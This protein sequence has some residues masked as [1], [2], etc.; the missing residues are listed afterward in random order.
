MKDDKFE[1]WFNEDRVAAVMNHLATTDD[2]TADLKAGVQRTEFLAKLAEAFAYKA[3]SVGSVE[4]KKAEAKM[5]PKVQEAWETHFKAIADYEKARA[6]RARGDM[7]F[8]GWRSRSA[9]RRQ[10]AMT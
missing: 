2:E 6:K 4:D 9:N 7:V 3:I 8:E 5:S 10:G 1:D